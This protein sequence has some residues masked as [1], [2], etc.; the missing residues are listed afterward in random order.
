M[1][2]PDCASVY[3]GYKNIKNYKNIKDKFTNSTQGFNNLS[4]G[5]KNLI[6]FLMLD[7]FYNAKSLQDD[8]N[9]LQVNQI[10]TI[11]PIPPITAITA[12]STPTQFL[13]LCCDL[14]SAANGFNYYMSRQKI[15][16][17][18]NPSLQ[19]QNSIVGYYHSKKKIWITNNNQIKF[20]IIAAK[21]VASKDIFDVLNDVTPTSVTSV[22]VGGTKNKVQQNGGTDDDNDEIGE[23]GEYM[24]YNTMADW[25]YDDDN[26]KKEKYDLNKLFK[27]VKYDVYGKEYI[28]SNCYFDI[29]SNDFVKKMIEMLKI[30]PR[31]NSENLK[32]IIKKC[33][34]YILTKFK[35]IPD[36]IYPPNEQIRLSND[37]DEQWKNLLI[38]SK[39]QNQLIQS[40][41]SIPQ[42][43]Q[44]PQKPQK[45]STYMNIEM[46]V[47][48][49]VSKRRYSEPQTPQKPSAYINIA[50][51]APK[52]KLEF[53]KENNPPNKKRQTLKNFGGFTKKKNKKKVNKKKTNKK[54]IKRMLRKTRRKR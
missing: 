44:T 3:A 14:A 5:M 17:P 16:V 19:N 43:P 32:D 41:Q 21:K 1:N 37:L 9:Q 48:Q 47:Q 10:T 2:A 40:I 38:V 33:A 39:S 46:G 51:G 42:T 29:F 11:P 22:T 52:R 7:Q 50:R 4:A 8:Q 35:L 34:I 26:F 18:P 28:S 45:P 6:P 54:R 15:S 49:N 24:Y 12:N 20:E 30:Y 13:G 27:R 31:K 23:Y 36:N 25:L 53:N